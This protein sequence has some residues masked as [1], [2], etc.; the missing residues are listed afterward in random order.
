MHVKKLFWRKYKFFQ[1]NI[2]RA[3]AGKCA[4]K[5]YN[6]LLSSYMPLTFKTEE[7]LSQKCILRNVLFRPL[8][9]FTECLKN[10]EPITLNFIDPDII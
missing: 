10:G 8:F 1:G 2:L 5:S 4:R 6:T 3:G 7:L 9:Y